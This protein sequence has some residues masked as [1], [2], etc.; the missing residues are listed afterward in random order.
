MA[1]KVILAEPGEDFS[2][3]RSCVGLACTGRFMDGWIDWCMNGR[4]D[5]WME[6]WRMEGLL[7][8]C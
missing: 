1:E 3:F 5:D 8:G 2:V 4:K 7:D 6:G